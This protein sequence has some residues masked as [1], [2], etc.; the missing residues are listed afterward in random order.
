AW[1][2]V[3]IQY[4]TYSI[5]EN[6]V[7]NQVNPNNA[8][9]ISVSQYVTTI[10]T[11]GGT[12]QGQISANGGT[13]YQNIARDNAPFQTET[14]PAIVAAALKW[15]GILQNTVSLNN[16]FIDDLTLYWRE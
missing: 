14:I 15:K 12:Y 5:A 2:E 13:N 8:D 9:I 10:L 4:T 1:L 7:I 6:A 11:G 3:D 16:Q